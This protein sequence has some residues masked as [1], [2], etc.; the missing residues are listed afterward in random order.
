[1]AGKEAAGSSTTDD[2]SMTLGR[3]GG[4]SIVNGNCLRRVPF[5]AGGFRD[6][7]AVVLYRRRGKGGWID[8]TRD[9]LA[10]GMNSAIEKKDAD[11]PNVHQLTT[12]RALDS[13]WNVKRNYSTSLERDSPEHRLDSKIFSSHFTSPSPIVL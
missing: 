13:C 10:F 12:V 4:I 5:H 3:F 6:F 1:M 2:V 11:G 9:T 7:G 8:R